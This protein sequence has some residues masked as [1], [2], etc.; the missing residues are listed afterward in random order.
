MPPIRRVVPLLAVLLLLAGSV[1]SAGA[2]TPG[3]AVYRV[4]VAAQGHSFSF[5]INETIAKTSNPDYQTLIVKIA[6]PGST[7]N[8]SR[9]VNASDYLSPF[10]PS[11]SNQT[12]SSG[13][14]MGR[15]S[16]N[17][18]KNGTRTLEFSG[19]SQT[20]T[21]YSLSVNLSVN[22]S[23]TSLQGGIAAFSSGLVQSAS[24]VASYPDIQTLG[25]PGMLAG[26]NTSGFQGAGPSVGLPVIP[27]DGGTA[28]LSIVLVA[29]S[30]PLN[31]ASASTAAKVVS[32]GI[33]AGAVVSALAVGLEVRRRSRHAAPAPESKPEHWVD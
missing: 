30:L 16:V 4:T 5:T 19:S 18:L 29:T 1:G 3:F 21:T 28:S 13:S 20:L 23:A 2:A 32:V 22:G 12:F 6:A 15:I 8:Y 33:G 11:I 27:V 14:S 17:L 26:L 9:S 7:Y 24:L 10:L 25:L 31:S